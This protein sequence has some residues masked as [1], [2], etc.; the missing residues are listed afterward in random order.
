MPGRRPGFYAAWRELAQHDMSGG[1]LGISDFAKKIAA[2]P[3]DPESAIQHSLTVLQ[4]PE[5][6]W[7]DYITRVLAQLPGWTGLIR[8]RGL[9]QDDPIQQAAPID[10]VQYLA[11]RLFYE[12]ELVGLQARRKWGG[13]GN[14][15]K[16]TNLLKGQG[17]APE[18]TVSPH[19]LA[20]SRDAWRLFHL[21]QLLDIDANSLSEITREQAG[22]LLGWLD[23]FSVEQQLPV[24]LE[25]YEESF[26]VDLLSNIKAHQGKVPTPKERPLAQAA[27]CIDVRSEP[28]RRHLEAAG[29]IDTYGYCLL[30]TSDAAD[31]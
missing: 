13:E 6:R 26:R 19:K 12:Q 1:L 17:K 16:V 5:A 11:V 3:G 4:I 2:L 28:F 15:T 22:S 18:A 30:Y 29:A 10:V 14:L 21:S 27:F 24:W 8:W 25:A 9:N 7:P 23:N 20:L 31:E